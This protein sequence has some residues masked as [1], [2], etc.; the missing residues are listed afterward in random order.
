MHKTNI[1][2]GTYGWFALADAERCRL[3]RCR[4][5]SQGTQHVD[6]YG[7]FDNA[8]PE[9]EHE[10]PMTMGGMTHDIEEEE[11]RFAGQIVAWLR[12]QAEEHQIDHLVIFA[13]PRMLGVLRKL[14]LGLLKGHLEELEGNLMRLEA[15]QLAEHPMV[16]KL[17]SVTREP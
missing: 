4:L 8:L 9:A 16:R 11:R 15:G 3:L 13:P 1:E 10:R 5:T 6:E 2:R 17:V 12:K 14:P 7:G